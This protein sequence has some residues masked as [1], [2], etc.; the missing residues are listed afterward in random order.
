MELLAT[1]NGIDVLFFVT[2]AVVGAVLA[3]SMVSHRS[4]R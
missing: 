3:R 4:R 1:I 2:G